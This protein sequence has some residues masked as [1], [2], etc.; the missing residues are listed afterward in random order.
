MI[1]MNDIVDAVNLLFLEKFP[2]AKAY[3]NRCPKDFKRPSYFLQLT[4]VSR[5][6]VSR[7]TVA[8]AV[9][10][11][12]TY[13]VPTDSRYIVDSEA[14]REAQDGMLEVF[15]PGFIRVNDRA[16]K[17]QAAEGETSLS[18][19]TITVRV[20]YYDERGVTTIVLPTA[21]AVKT[22]INQEG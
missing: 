3:V 15:A 2:T 13:F 1:K 11:M 5:D 18:D 21:S 7:K 20:D 6:D 17:L 12:I 14:L 16:L 10:L 9:D 19:T 22:T 4:G 8:V